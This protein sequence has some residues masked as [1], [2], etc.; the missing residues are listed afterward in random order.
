MQFGIRVTLNL[1]Q[2]PSGSLDRWLGSPAAMAI[3]HV[4][5]QGLRPDGP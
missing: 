3:Y 4:K 1:F 5:E 2:G